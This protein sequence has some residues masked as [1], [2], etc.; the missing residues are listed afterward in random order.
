MR[1]ANRIAALYSEDGPLVLDVE[2]ESVEI[3]NIQLAATEGTLSIRGRATSRTIAETAQVRIESAGADLRLAEVRA[4]VET[5]DC[6]AL[7]GAAAARCTVRN[8]ARGPAASALAAALTS[9]YRGRPLR[10]FIAPPPFS[11][12]LG[13]RR[14]TMRLVPVRASSAGGSLIV[15]GKADVE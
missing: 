10:A 7:S 8:A 5:E 3:R 12:D 11:F 9:R 1:F 4:E 6:N 13:G 15:Y 14:M 2:R